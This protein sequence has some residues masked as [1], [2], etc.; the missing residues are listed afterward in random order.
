MRKWTNENTND[1]TKWN[2]ERRVKLNTTQI[3]FWFGKY[4]KHDIY[5]TINWVQFQC[6]TTASASCWIEKQLPHFF[7]HLINTPLLYLLAAI[8]YARSVQK[9][10]QRRILSNSIRPKTTSEAVAF[11]YNQVLHCV[12]MQLK[13]TETKKKKIESIRTRGNALLYADWYYSLQFRSLWLMQHFRDERAFSDKLFFI[14]FF[15]FNTETCVWV[16]QTFLLVFVQLQFSSMLCHTF[17][18]CFVQSNSKEQNSTFGL[19]IVCAR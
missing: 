2:Y 9:R 4:M 1:R 13:H 6:R 8:F 18:Y 17:N 14:F 7:S 15:L 3:K 12:A 16:Q 11:N 19:S 5:H 10:R